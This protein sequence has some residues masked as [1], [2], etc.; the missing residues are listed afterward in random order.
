MEPLA[1]SGSNYPYLEQISMVT[2]IF[3]PLKFD[4]TLLHMKM[5]NKTDSPILNLL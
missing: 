5:L 4:R 1:L 2:K 3:E